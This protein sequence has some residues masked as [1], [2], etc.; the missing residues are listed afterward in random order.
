MNPWIVLLSIAAPAVVYIW[1]PVGLTMFGRFRRQQNLRGPE[2]GEEARLLFDP[3]R[4]AV[5]ACFGRPSLRIRYCS[6]RPARRGCRHKCA[7]LNQSYMRDAAVAGP[8]PR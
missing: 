6:I 2:T 7:G 4:A 1:F 3:G 8:K 5:S